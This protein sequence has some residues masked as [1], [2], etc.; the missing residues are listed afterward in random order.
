MRKIKREEKKRDNF[1]LYVPHRSDKVEWENRKGKVVFIF[2][3]NKLI[4]KT[5]RIFV[6]RPKTTTLE[7][8]EIGS[9]VWNLINGE[10]NVYEIGQKLKEKFGDE[11]EPLYERLIM[12]IR[13]LNRRGWIYFSRSG[14]S[15]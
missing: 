4:E 9:A 2:H 3:H 12:F 14:H 15:K 7:L 1:L 13:Y 10:R 5:V 8:D 6:K 11:V